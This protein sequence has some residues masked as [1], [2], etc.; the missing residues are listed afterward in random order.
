[1][2]P[3]IRCPLPPDFEPNKLP[4][5]GDYIS[6]LDL[7]RKLTH[8]MQV[9]CAVTAAEIA[10]P[11]WQLAFGEHPPNCPVSPEA[12]QLTPGKT[13]D[14][15]HR[16]LLGEADRTAVRYAITANANIANW[17]SGSTHRAHRLAA[18][19][20]SAVTH[21]GYTIINSKTHANA[22]YAIDSAV[23]AG[24]SYV[25]WWNKCKPLLQEEYNHWSRKLNGAWSREFNGE[26]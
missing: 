7:M 17:A 12:F 19:V 16:W 2:N 23:A 5:P 9:I 15:I 8:R 21:A 1:M 14:I 20:A 25:D 11:V 4:A 22:A 10:L 24:V 18:E 3:Y 13:I 26:E 6:V